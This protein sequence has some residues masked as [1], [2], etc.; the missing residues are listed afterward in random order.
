MAASLGT[1]FTA[2]THWYVLDTVATGHTSYT[3]TSLVLPAGVT[4]LVVVQ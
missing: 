4:L 1:G 2:A 3:R